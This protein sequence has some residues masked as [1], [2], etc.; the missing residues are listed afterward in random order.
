[1]DTKG[2]TMPTQDTP[3]ETAPVPGTRL[4]WSI[5]EAAAMLSVSPNHLRRMA[6]RGELRVVRVGPRRVVIPTEELTRILN[7]DASSTQ[8]A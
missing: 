8:E 7:G 5:P 2:A 1:M 3:L 6:E 4:A